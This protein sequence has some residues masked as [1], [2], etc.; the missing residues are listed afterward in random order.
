STNSL[1]VFFPKEK[2]HRTI[3]NIRMDMDDHQIILSAV[4]GPPDQFI[5]KQ[6]IYRATT[7][8][9]NTDVVSVIYMDGGRFDDFTRGVF[10][11][12]DGATLRL[13]GPTPLLAATTNGDYQ[14]GGRVCNPIIPINWILHQSS[15]DL[16]RDAKAVSAAKTKMTRI[17]GLGRKIILGLDEASHNQG[18]VLLRRVQPE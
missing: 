1:I 2:T 18:A 6:I 3:E 13:T 11:G 15:D 16:E 9:N 12:T 17:Y 7:Y 8:F 14:C 4:G 5:R 10:V